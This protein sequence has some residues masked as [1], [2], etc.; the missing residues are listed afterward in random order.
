MTEHTDIDIDAF[1]A[2]ISVCEAKGFNCYVV[3]EENSERR[4]YLIKPT[5][6]KLV[7]A[8]CLTVYNTETKETFTSALE[9]DVF[10]SETKIQTFIEQRRAMAVPYENFYENSINSKFL[11]SGTTTKVY[12]DSLVK[13]VKVQAGVLGLAISI[14][15]DNITGGTAKLGTYVTKHFSK[16]AFERDVRN[17]YFSCSISPQMELMGFEYLATTENKSKRNTFQQ[18]TK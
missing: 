13:Q 12:N 3:A 14:Y 16:F 8:K 1:I 6:G 5:V 7:K 17:C 18:L 9:W 4:V 15:K 10:P 11:M 2:Q